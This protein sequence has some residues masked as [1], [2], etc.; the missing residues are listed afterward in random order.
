MKSL[1]FAGLMCSA[2]TVF[3]GEMIISPQE[4][5]FWGNAPAGVCPVVTEQTYSAVCT[6]RN[7]LLTVKDLD[8]FEAEENPLLTF[9]ITLPENSRTMFHCYWA[10]Q[11]EPRMHENRSFHQVLIGT[12]KPQLCTVNLAGH[13]G[14][15]EEPSGQSALIRRLCGECLFRFR[16]VMSSSGTICRDFPFTRLPGENLCRCGI[17]P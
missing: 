4:W 10:T 6:S 8:S 9:S 7:V 12:G 1:L 5:Q 14:Y 16:L 17:I 15:R 2:F 11:S 3:S 13:P